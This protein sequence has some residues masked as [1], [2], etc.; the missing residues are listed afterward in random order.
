MKK[1][2]LIAV[3]VLFTSVT[4]AQ[5]TLDYASTN[6]KLFSYTVDISKVTVPDTTIWQT[7]G[8]NTT[9]QIEYDSLTLT[10]TG[11]TINILTKTKEAKAGINLDHPYLPHTIVDAGGG[12]FTGNFTG[13]LVG[14]KITFGSA[15]AGILYF[16]LL[17]KNNK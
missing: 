9:V 2:L 1:L 17:E 7:I 15:S 5:M 13:G 16:T 8:W 3:I 11:A 12:V 6:T 4:Y 14:I 10:G